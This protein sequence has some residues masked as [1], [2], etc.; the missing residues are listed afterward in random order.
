MSS[1]E[2]FVIKVL[3]GCL[4][5]FVSVI[6]A[7]FALLAA[8]SRSAQLQAARQWCSEKLALIEATG[9]M[10]LP[11][12]TVLWLLK[13]QRLVTSSL[14]DILISRAMPYLGGA[15]TGVGYLWVLF[16]RDR[17]LWVF[18]SLSFFLIFGLSEV[19]RHRIQ[20]RQLSR[21]I[22]AIGDTFAFL[23]LGT[24][25]TLTLIASLSYTS[26]L[27]SSCVMLAMLPLSFYIVAS[28]TMSLDSW[29]KVICS[30]YAIDMTSV[31]R[32]ALFGVGAGASF[33]VTITALWIGHIAAPGDIVPRT[34]QLVFVNVVCDGATLLA[35]F[36]ILGRAVRL[37]R[38]WALPG[39]VLVDLSVAAALACASLLLGLWGS[40]YAVSAHE[41]LRILVAAPAL[42]G[43]QHLGPLFWAM[44]SAFLPTAFYLTLVVLSLLLKA[45]AWAMTRA[46]RVLSSSDL[47]PFAV[48]AA[49]FALVFTLLTALASGAGYF[50]EAAKKTSEP[51]AQG[52]EFRPRSAYAERAEVDGPSG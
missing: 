34:C 4:A 51:K 10:V 43:G 29:W 7:T 42:K 1:S 17:D 32:L 22:E 23:G 2:W 30:R 11:E 38:R 47:N 28:A 18:A 37:N 15:L 20:Y 9:V 39:A 46:L 48:S 44:H 41:V 13:V 8:A 14:P 6:S 27:V 24:L 3:L 31:D 16:V 50:E 35:T 36:V 45:V 5:G 26:L 40:D 19:I 33:F 12:Q 52:Q 49:A 25:Y 21:V